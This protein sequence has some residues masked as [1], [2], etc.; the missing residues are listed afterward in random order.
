M[1]GAA[2]ATENVRDPPSPLALQL[3]GGGVIA[4][5]HRGGRA[6]DSQLLES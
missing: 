1:A 5:V 2:E 3:R 6:V 4:A